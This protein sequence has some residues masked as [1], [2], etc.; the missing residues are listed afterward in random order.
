MPEA[1]ASA[2][3]KEANRLKR[4]AERAGNRGMFCVRRELLRCQN[5]CE[6]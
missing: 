1:I 5:E 4:Q 2:V 6:A 3:L